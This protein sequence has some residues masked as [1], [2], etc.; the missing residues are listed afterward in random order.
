MSPVSD[1]AVH[2][3]AAVYGEG[4]S[5]LAVDLLVSQFSFEDLHVLNFGYCAALSA[6][7]KS[8]VDGVVDGIEL[9]AGDGL[10]EG[11]VDGGFGGIVEGAESVRLLLVG[12]SGRAA[13]GGRRTGGRKK[14]RFPPK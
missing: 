11:V 5:V 6:C 12:T 13:T 2:A 1:E 10:C 4:G 7:E 8:A 14:M 3:P 9:I